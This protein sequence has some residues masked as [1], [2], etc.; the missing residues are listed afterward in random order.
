MPLH[1]FEPRYRAMV[2]YA[3]ENFGMIGMVQPKDVNDYSEHPAI[4]DTGCLGEDQFVP[5][6]RRWK[7]LRRT[8]RC[9]PI[10]N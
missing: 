7:V 6:D 2:E 10:F 1:I 5:T 3:V 8:H 9:L 4:Y